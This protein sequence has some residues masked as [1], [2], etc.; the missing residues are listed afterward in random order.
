MKI[1]P[2][3]QVPMY[4]FD[5]WSEHE[6]LQPELEQVCYDLQQQNNQSGVAPRAKSLYESDFDFF[7][8]DNPVVKELL[9]Y[10]RNAVFQAAQHAN[11][12]RWGAGT[13][14]GISIHESWCHITRAGGWH[15]AH[16][17]PNSSWSGIYY[18]RAGDSSADSASGVNRF[19][20]PWPAAYSD[21]GTRYSSQVSS[22]DIEPA[23]GELIIFPSW[24]LH[25]ATVYQGEQDR[26]I[27]AFNCKFIDGSPDTTIHI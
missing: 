23:D 4:Q 26:I 18:I 12:G 13:R 3:W 1:V 6:R 25:S 16:T 21:I 24:L 5:A 20:S 15:D 22:I 10:V 27:V 9:E 19:Y 7:Q 17:H 14:I 2:A 11:Q 8:L